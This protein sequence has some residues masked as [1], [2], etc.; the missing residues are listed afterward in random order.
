MEDKNLYYLPTNKSIQ[1]LSSEA[2]H[3]QFDEY[4]PLSSCITYH[5]RK[6]NWL[7]TRIIYAA[8]IIS[9]NVENFAY[10]MAQRTWYH[11][12]ISFVE[13]SMRP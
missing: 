11:N 2:Q 5:H 8:S 7:H 9:L 6:P 4:N 1:R 10:Y 13:I 12:Y 3:Y